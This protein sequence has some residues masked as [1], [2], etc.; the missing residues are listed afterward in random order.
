MR[1]YLSGAVTGTSDYVERFEKAEKRLSSQGIEIINPVKVNAQLPISTTH[2]EYMKVSFTL[3][4]MCDAIYLLKGWE[5]SK[6]AKQE[7]ARAILLDK[8]ITLEY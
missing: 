6:G 3:L 2:D 8:N 7:L 4:D 5:N 1:L